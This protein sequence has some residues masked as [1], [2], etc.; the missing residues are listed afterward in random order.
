MIRGIVS[1]SV[2]RPVVA[3]GGVLV[4]VVLVF[5]VLAFFSL[6]TRI[7]DH[8]EWSTIRIAN[9]EVPIA[10]ADP[11]SHGPQIY[12]GTPTVKPDFVDESFGPDVSFRMRSEPGA[13][14]SESKV[15]RAVYLGH[16]VGGD[17]YYIWQEGFDGIGDLL[18]QILADFGSVG[19][20]ESSYGTYDTGP[21]LFHGDDSEFIGPTVQF[22]E[23]DTYEMVA[24][25]HSLPKNVVAVVLSE[26]GQSLGWQAPVSGTVGFRD[27]RDE[28]FGRVE[29]IAYEASG[30][31]WAEQVVLP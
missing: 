26:D 23:S 16:D 2:R 15:L 12:L 25:W 29:M 21:G 9:R 30:E 31:I 27:E 3:V 1:R 8:G 22:I 17:P 20:F 5:A 6:S 19:R 24:E 28:R 11:V 7:V 10:S 13:G 4:A 14:L 18:G